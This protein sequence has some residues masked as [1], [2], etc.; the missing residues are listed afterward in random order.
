[1]VVLGFFV[2]LFWRL[3]FVVIP[4]GH[5]G[6]RY[7]LFRGTRLGL[8]A[9]EGLNLK[10]PWNRM[11]VYDLRLQALPQKVFGLSREGMSIYVDIVVMFRPDV[12]ALPRLHTEVGPEYAQTTVTPLSVGAARQFIAQHDSHELYTTEADALQREIL[13]GT[14]AQLAQYHVVVTAVLLE[15]LTLPKAVLE[16]IEQKLTQEQLA[17][18]YQFRLEAER[19]EA[20]RL[21]I[22]GAGLRRYYSLVD[23]VLTP[24]LLTWR[25]IEAT[26]ELAQ[27]SNTKIV[28]VGSGKDQLPLILGSDIGKLPE[29]STARPGPAGP[30][31]GP[32]TSPRIFPPGDRTP[33]PPGTPGQAPPQPTTPPQ[34]R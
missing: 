13:T 6:V 12:A 18:A 15:R 32:V 10:F 22:K 14:R 33:G 23:S 9:R 21:D 29:A 16:A 24:S 8:I 1:V 7:D 20:Q 3:I 2:L 4:P 11:Y 5:A 27:S 28:I 25:G 19:A 17:A 30:A 34:Q 26:V 31:T